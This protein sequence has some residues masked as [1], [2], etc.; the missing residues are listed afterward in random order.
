MYYTSLIEFIKQRYQDNFQ[1][2]HNYRCRCKLLRKP[3]LDIHTT[4]LDNRPCHTMNDTL[5]RRIP[6]VSEPNRG[7]A[8]VVLWTR[9]KV[10]N[11]GG[12]VR[13]AI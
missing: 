6:E 5:F 8:N 10:N 2:I 12:N 7:K 11:M 1:Y 3:R 13:G 9:E 4:L